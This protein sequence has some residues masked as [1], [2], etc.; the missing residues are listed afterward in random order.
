MNAVQES[1]RRDSATHADVIVVGGG[2]AGMTAAALVARAG[3]SV[4][5]LEQVHHLGGR[6]AT[7]V[8]DGVR[9]N[10]GA[11][12]L[13]AGGR[14]CGLL[15]ELAVPFSG[16]F[17]SPGRPLVVSRRGAY[18]IPAGLGSLACSSLLSLGEK[19]R[20][21]RLFTTI[22]RLD[23]RLLDRASA[24][25]WIE[26]T[27]GRGNLASLLGALFRVSTYVADQERLSAGAALDQL[28]MA[29]VTNV[30]YLDGGWQTLIEGLRTAATGHGAEVRTSAR[31][32]TVE[33]LTSSA[34][35][36]LAGGAELCSRAVIL[37][38]PPD[39]AC[40]LLS[41]PS[42]APLR[43]WLSRQSPVPA[44]CL[45]I[46]FSRLPRPGD[47]F[48]LGLD[49]PTYFSVHS[50]AARLAADGTAVVHLMKYLQADADEPAT[51][52]EAELEAL[53]DKV[54]AGWRAHVVARRFLPKMTVAHALPRADEGGLSGRP[55]PSLA[56]CPN[57][58]VAGDW[59][60]PEGMLADAA[61]A[62][63][64]QAARCAL[65]LIDD[66]RAPM[67]VAD[68]REG[69]LDGSR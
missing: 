61:T 53:L 38:V 8:I 17:P 9:F 46:A 23:T 6:A 20:L 3:R 27:A 43:T 35:L 47:R 65:A 32:R 64:Q 51:A 16:H 41:M 62:S 1:L 57:V 59:V 40:S 21:A 5:V 25:D 24:R 36:I 69:V 54:Q 11:H 68:Q 12:A 33:N 18:R 7:N 14:A 29:L 45:D 66:R 4:I 22:K 56:G 19:M 26:Q 55:K 44:A 13:Y 49:Q 39:A 60:G 67:V 34:R 58:F 10:L 30:L 31:V 2:L 52:V 37:A 63:A 28:R 48:A 50:A 15:N 42:D